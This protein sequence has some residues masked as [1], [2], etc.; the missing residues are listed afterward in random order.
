[1]LIFVTLS[2]PVIEDKV[3]N[4]SY[5]LKITVNCEKVVVGS[6]LL[7]EIKEALET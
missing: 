5:E 4:E 1:V 7:K 3:A 6:I 2:C